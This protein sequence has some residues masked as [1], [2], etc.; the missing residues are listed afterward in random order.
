MEGQSSGLARGQGAKA[1]MAAMWVE[2]LH[3]KEPVG[4]EVLMDIGGIL[5]D[6]RGYA[7]GVQG[8]LSGGGPRGPANTGRPVGP[9]RARARVVGAAGGQ[10]AGAS[11]WQTSRLGYSTEVWAEHGRP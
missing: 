8:G 7:D 1:G 5:V 3:E 9:E 6:F 4:L 10:R 11:P 2:Y